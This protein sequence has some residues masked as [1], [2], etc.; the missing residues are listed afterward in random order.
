[1]LIRPLLIA[2]LTLAGIASADAQIVALG[3]SGTAG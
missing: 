3:A 1:M 2:L